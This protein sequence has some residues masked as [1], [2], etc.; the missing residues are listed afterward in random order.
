MFNN[1]QQLGSSQWQMS[2]PDCYNFNHVLRRFMHYLQMS[3]V[4]QQTTSP[5]Q[6][7]QQSAAMVRSSAKSVWSDRRSAPVVVPV[8][9]EFEENLLSNEVGW[10][11]ALRDLKHCLDLLD[12]TT[13]RVDAPHEA[14]VEELLDGVS[15][16][17]A[18]D[19]HGDADSGEW[20]GAVVDIDLSLDEQEELHPL[21]A[22]LKANPKLA[23]VFQSSSS[24]ALYLAE[25]RA[26]PTLDAEQEKALAL[27]I[28]E[29][30]AAA[31]AHMI[32]AHL[33]LV[34][35][36]ARSLRAPNM[37]LEDLI[38]DGNMGLIEAVSRFDPHRGVRFATYAR[39]WIKQSIRQGILDHSRT[40]RLPVHVI[41]DVTKVLREQRKGQAVSGETASPGTSSELSRIAKA[42]GKTV[43]EVAHLMNH[44]QVPLSMDLPV[45]GEE[46]MVLADTI[47]DVEHG[48]PESQL[49][50]DQ[51]LDTLLGCVNA[52]SKIERV[53]IL[54]RYGFETGEPDT[55]ENVGSLLGL[56]AERVRQIQKSA[57]PKLREELLKRGLDAA[58]LFG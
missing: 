2:R 26:V 51:M 6:P 20:D 39:F 15:D 16:S 46:S 55:L 1:H 33:G 52:L 43:H 27:Q 34:V 44:A 3:N 45:R 12:E 19:A 22:E 40:V 31:V 48:T 49:V 35:V 9:F 57:L 17:W 58:A 7:R 5:S 28:V 37:P 41:R 32:R 10:V 30:D 54:R 38:G 53:V 21:R 50:T 29:G 24:L 47:E 14:M 42:T 23:E 36:V 18:S 4:M 25:I 13:A 11:N 56:T 8:P